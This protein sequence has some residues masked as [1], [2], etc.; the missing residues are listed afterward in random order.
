MPDERR[1]R[2]PLYGAFEGA[3]VVPI[4]IMEDENGAER[5]RSR[6]GTPSDLGLVG[7]VPGNRPD[8]R[9]AQQAHILD[10]AARLG[11]PVVEMERAE[12]GAPIVRRGR[13]DLVWEKEPRE[14]VA[15]PLA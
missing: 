7:K 1:H 12:T 11:V 5:H 8:A 13:E 10:T 9:L 3:V 6:R 15:F 4:T 14:D 2:D